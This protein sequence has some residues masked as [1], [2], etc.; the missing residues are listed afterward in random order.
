[1]NLKEKIV[2]DLVESYFKDDPELAKL[3]WQNNPELREHLIGLAI[4]EH[5]TAGTVGAPLKLKKVLKG[6]LTVGGLVTLGSALGIKPLQ[7][8]PIFGSI[9]KSVYN[10]FSGTKGG[11][12]GALVNTVVPVATALAGATATTSVLNAMQS[13]YGPALGA[14]MYL[15]RISEKL[16]YPLPPAMVNKLPPDI[17][18]MYNTGSQYAEAIATDPSVDQLLNELKKF[19]KPQPIQ[20]TPAPVQPAIPWTAIAIGGL[21]LVSLLI[22]MSKK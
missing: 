8:V 22:L 19:Q 15:D 16:P 2:K 7:K 21:A 3:L 17:Q 20:S 14:D 5:I 1:M 6:V 18:N 4:Q 11:V 12:A 10:A 13:Q 9:G